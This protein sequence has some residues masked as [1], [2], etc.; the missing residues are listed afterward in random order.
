M[1]K[2]GVQIFKAVAFLFSYFPESFI[3][4]PEI[5]EVYHNINNQ[6][7]I[8]IVKQRFICSDAINHEI[9]YTHSGGHPANRYADVM[10]KDITGK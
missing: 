1:K 8:N 3:I 7:G 4:N 10:Q 9:I 5:S 6:E 2:P